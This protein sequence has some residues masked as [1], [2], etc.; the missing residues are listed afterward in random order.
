MYIVQLFQELFVVGQSE[1][2][3]P[4]VELIM[5]DGSAFPHHLKYDVKNDLACIPYSSGTTGLP[6]GVMLTHYNIVAN[7]FQCE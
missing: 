4:L 7:M 3:V 6:K 5:D 1:G 2:C